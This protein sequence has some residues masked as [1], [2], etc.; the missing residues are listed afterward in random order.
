[1]ANTERWKPGMT[2][3]NWQ[4]LIG[5]WGRDKG[6]WKPIQDE[7]TFDHVVKEKLLLIVSE[8]AEATEELRKMKGYSD[9]LGEELADI[10]IRSFQLADQLNIDL[11]VE[12]IEKM[13]KNERRPFK[14]GKRF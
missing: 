13:R 11:E 7:N 2:L 9:K 1:M 3:Q 8:V 12:L 6:F 5:Q 14:H 4:R 10:V